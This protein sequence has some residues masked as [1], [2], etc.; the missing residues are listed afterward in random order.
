MHFLFACTAKRLISADDLL[1]NGKGIVRLFKSVVQFRK[2]FK[3]IILFTVLASP[4]E[5]NYAN[6]QILAKF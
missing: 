2:A 4:L 3:L 5:E 1:A 6:K